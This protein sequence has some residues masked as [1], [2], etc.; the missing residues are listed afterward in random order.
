MNNK[1][2]I[3]LK[4]KN[5]NNNVINILEKIS[6]GNSPKTNYNNFKNLNKILM[7]AICVLVGI[8]ITPTLIQKPS[9]NVFVRYNS[10]DS[11]NT[12]DKEKTVKNK[13]NKKDKSAKKLNHEKSNHQKLKSKKP[14]NKTKPKNAFKLNKSKEKTISKCQNTDVPYLN[15]LTYQNNIYGN[16]VSN[17]LN[18]NFLAEEDN[19]FYYIDYNDSNYVYRTNI[20]DG[21]TDLIL[22]IPCKEINVLN[23]KLYAISSEFDNELIIYDLQ[24][25]QYQKATVN[26]N[27]LNL[28]CDYAISCDENGIYKTF[29]YDTNK[30]GKEIYSGDIDKCALYNQTIYFIESD[31]L[32]SIDIDGNNKI[33][34]KENVQN[35][36][37]SNS[38]IYYVFNNKLYSLDTE[39]PLYD[40]LL[41]AINIYDNTIYFSNENDDGKLYSI[42]I[43]TSEIQK[44]SDNIVEKICVT[45]NKIAVI[46]P[47][48]QIIFV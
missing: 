35:F 30:I 43:T 6:K 7:C 5:S 27:Y 13:S 25:N 21:K 38:E 42:N 4:N 22:H 23:G 34:I 26:E 17:V 24:T 11:P 48:H 40:I 14:K 37:I 31:N 3:E 15:N 32:Y 9:K 16:S 33:L 36:A 47:D 10:S 29:L 44:L 20:L 2:K 19:W 28:S 18:G 46:T 39:E 1:S 8:C 41:S 12:N 45:K